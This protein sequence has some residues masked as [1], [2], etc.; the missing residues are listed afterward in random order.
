MPKVRLLRENEEVECERGTNLYALLAARDLVDGPCGGKGVCGKCAVGVDARRVLACKYAVEK[1][2]DVVTAPKDDIA[3]IEVSGYHVEVEPDPADEGALGL[4]VDVGTTTV[5][6][7]LVELRSGAELRSASCLNSQK[8]YGQDV[9]TRIHFTMDEPGGLAVLAGLVRADLE[10]L[11]AAV[12]AEEGV[13]PS[14]VRRVVVSG[15]TTMVHLFAGV[16]PS[17]IAQAPFTPRLTGAVRGTGADFG[18]A[19]LAEAEVFCVPC[20]AAYV[21]GDIVSG[22]VAC[23]LLA[24]ASGRTLF[25]DIGT[26]GEIVLADA[27]ELVTCSCAAGPALEGMNISCGMRASAGAIEDVRIEGDSLSYRTI[28]GGEPRGICGSGIVAAVGQGV[29]SGVIGRSGRLSKASPLVARRDGRLALVLDEARGLYLTQ[30]DVR[31][32]QLSKG[33]ILAAIEALL[34]DRGL[35]AGDVA[36]VAVSGQFGRHLSAESLVDA[37]FFPRAWEGR[38]TYTGN[39]SQSGAVLCLVS[40]EMRARSERVGS[41]AHYLE[42]STLE[43]YDRLFVDAMAF[44]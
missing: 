5:V 35:A 4:A 25:I 1:D 38:I 16:D 30:G 3:D 43:G 10:R 31:Q 7:T 28:G 17:S 22:V 34:H 37:G 18:L 36:R 23:D 24:P 6:V 2:V 32:V 21:G 8:A 39:T 11:A 15:N 9:I 41:H 19:S 42:L 12:C 33:A 40:E 26:N 27:G 13:D 14:Q 29:A 44:G 20:V